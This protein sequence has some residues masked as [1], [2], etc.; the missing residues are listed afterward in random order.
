M[1]NLGYDAD[2][3]KRLMGAARIL[4]Q[5]GNEVQAAYKTQR[6]HNQM[7]V[8]RAIE[9]MYVKSAT[10]LMELAPEYVDE[11]LRSWNCAIYDNA[12]AMLW[13]FHQYVDPRIRDTEWGRGQEAVQMREEFRQELDT[14]YQ[15]GGR[16]HKRT[17]DWSFGCII[18]TADG[19]VQIAPLRRIFIAKVEHILPDHINTKMDRCTQ[20]TRR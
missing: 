15:S 7:E 20:C 11:E 17:K 14:I 2:E 12:R 16:S 10:K 19:E 3:F 1:T 18:P 13:E 9:A 8:Q 6:Q 4:D 5:H